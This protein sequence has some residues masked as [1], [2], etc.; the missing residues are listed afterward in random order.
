[1]DRKAVAL[2]YDQKD[3]APKILAKGKRKV[4][5][6]IVQIAR[7]YGIPIKEDEELVN[8]LFELQI[9]DYIPEDLFAIIAELLAFIYRMRLD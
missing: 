7:E 8:V 9:E 4:A 5:E 2:G 6:Q 1:M 3:I